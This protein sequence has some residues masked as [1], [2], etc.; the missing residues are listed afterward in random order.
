MKPE[1]DL[2][3]L[4]KKIGYQWEEIGVYLGL[5]QHTIKSIDSNFRYQCVQEKAF[6]MLV[7]WC[8]YVPK[9]MDA[10]VLLTRALRACGMHDVARDVEL[11]AE[12]FHGPSEL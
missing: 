11:P 6:D 5:H 9:D 2:L 3:S 4:S 12:I 1:L 10:S 7:K 8:E